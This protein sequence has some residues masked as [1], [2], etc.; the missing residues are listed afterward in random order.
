MIEAAAAAATGRLRLQA[1]DF[2]RDPLPVADTY[3]IMDVIHDWD[4]EQTT[5]LRPNAE[6]R[7]AACTGAGDRDRHR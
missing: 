6:H 3:L 2:F 7:A 5:A 4:D 1:G